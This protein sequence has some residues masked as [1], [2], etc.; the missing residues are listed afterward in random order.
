MA[1]GDPF[2]DLSDLINIATG[3]TAEQV[4]YY[5][6][7]FLG[8]TGT[9]VTAPVVGRR[10]SM[11]RWDGQPGGASPSSLPTTSA[12]CTNTTAG[13]LQQATPAAGAKK[14]L[15]G[16]AFS[17]LNAGT[18]VLYDRLN[19]SGGLSGLTSGAQTTNLPT[20]ALTRRT[21]GQGV[22]AWLEIY[23]AVG[24]TG[25]TSTLSYTNSA[26]TSGRTSQTSTFG[27]AGFDEK[28][29]ILPQTLASG[30]KGVQAVASVTLAASTLTAGNFGVVL[31]YP[32]VSL[33]LTQ[34]GVGGIMSAFLLSGGPLD[35]GTNSDAC[36][37]AYW[38]A[39]TTTAPY[40]N[41]QVF[42]TEK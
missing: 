40:I 26:G 30:D 27:T 37:A 38:V 36:I 29:R 25:T 19:Q 24:T 23:T 31:A 28:D 8:G 39:N 35:L 18:I 2:L 16:C 3:T 15:L 11:F 21:S 20:A 9:A 33:P 6:A 4:P 22:E 12:A 14:R 1:A 17:A 13:G 42:F 5:R 34:P 7:P 10:H 41:G 32:L